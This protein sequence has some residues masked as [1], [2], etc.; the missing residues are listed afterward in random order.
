MTHS[1]ARRALI[2]V[3]G[4]L[5]VLWLVQFVNV[6]MGYALDADFAIRAHV[7]TSLPDIF[8]APLLH[9]SWAHIEGNTL[10]FLILGFL[11]ALRGL[12]KFIYASGIIILTSGLTVWLLAP[13]GSFT[14]GASGLIAGWLGYVMLR[15]L[16]DH[17]LSDILLGFVA[18][19]LYLGAF[20]FLP[21]NSGISWQDHLG[22]FIGGLLAAYLLRTTRKRTE[23]EGGNSDEC[24]H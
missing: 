8:S 18:A 10:P 12:K 15:G 16:M 21:N 9:L 5:A 7:L 3:L 17:R 11:A 23:S 6:S 14:V 19:V 1:P 13:A 24:H 4:L 22:G 20:D 2:V